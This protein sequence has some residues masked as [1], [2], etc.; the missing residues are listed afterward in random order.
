VSQETGVHGVRAD[1]A[2]AGEGL[3]ASDVSGA[4]SQPIVARLAKFFPQASPV[5]IPVEV[6]AG[7]VASLGLTEQTVV[8][9][10]TP[11]EVLF[12]S[13]LPLE[14]GDRLRI[15]TADGSLDAEVFVVAVQY[16]SGRTAAA[17]RFSQ[18][19]KN[20]IVKR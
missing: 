20:W 2:R 19:V 4:A 5:R 11:D 8:E 9:F 1:G 14:F 18:A 7:E 16:H 10:G 12:A 3:F 17:A 15:R 13:S 6:V